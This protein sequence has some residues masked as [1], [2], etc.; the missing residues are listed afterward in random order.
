[1]LTSRSRSTAT[2]GVTSV[3]PMPVFAAALKNLACVA[4]SVRAR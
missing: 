3:L 4:A 2:V 1:M